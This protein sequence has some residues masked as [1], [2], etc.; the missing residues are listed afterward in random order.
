MESSTPDT[1]ALAGASRRKSMRV[2]QRPE[3]Y[4]ETT[5]T[6]NAKRKRSS[7]DDDDVEMEDA[8]TG[9]EDAESAEEESAADDRE[10]GKRAKRPKNSRGKPTAKKAKTKGET[11][12]LPIRP[13][14]EKTRRPKKAKPLKDAA[15]AEKAGGLYGEFRLAPI[16]LLPDANGSPQPM[17]LPGC[18]LSTK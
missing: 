10:R 7:A 18:C 1:E 3:T 15:A 11:V 12:S 9:E 6:N 16:Y 14:R 2:Q 13:M 8:A 5:T 17:C 4:N